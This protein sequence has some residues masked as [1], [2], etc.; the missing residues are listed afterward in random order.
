MAEFKW[1]LSDAEI[2]SW[3][4]SEI[5]RLGE[6][7]DRFSITWY[8][9]GNHAYGQLYLWSESKCDYGKMNHPYGKG[10]MLAECHDPNGLWLETIQAEGRKLYHRLKK[11]YPIARDLG[12][13]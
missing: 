1:L 8:Y 3:M 12:R 4:D 6:W 11:D 7:F 13:K 10:K 5:V 2:R 9:S